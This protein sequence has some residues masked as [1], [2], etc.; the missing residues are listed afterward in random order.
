MLG[1]LDGHVY[2]VWVVCVGGRGS[3][4]WGGGVWGVSEVYQHTIVVWMQGERVHIYPI[5]LYYI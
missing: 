1:M 4:L 3:W 5:K 2:R